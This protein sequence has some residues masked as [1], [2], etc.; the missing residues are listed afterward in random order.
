MKGI[1]VAIL[2][3]IMA[4]FVLFATGLLHAQQTVTSAQPQVAER[5]DIA[6]GDKLVIA[7]QSA[8]IA[9]INYLT[10]KDALDQ[11]V[12]NY[13]SVE[14]ALIASEK[15]PKGT[16]FEVKNGKVVAQLPAK[17]VFDDKTGKK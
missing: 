6:N 8:T 12:A 1:I 7:F 10:A 9:N 3:V 16:Q 11:A 17:P 15:L 13:H 14:D 2:V 4:I 5:R